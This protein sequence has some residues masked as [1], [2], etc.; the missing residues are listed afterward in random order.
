M[1]HKKMRE[2]MG[3]K[4]GGGEVKN[5]RTSARGSSGYNF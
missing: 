3:D 5:H 2:A 1:R 4:K